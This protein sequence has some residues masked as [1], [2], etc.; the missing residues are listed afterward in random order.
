MWQYLQVFIFIYWLALFG[1]VTIVFGLKKLVSDKIAILEQKRS[2]QNSESTSN[3]IPKNDSR[4]EANH[5]ILLENKHIVLTSMRK[6]FHFFI[7]LVFLLGVF[8]DR[9]LLFLCSYGMLICLA[10][11]EVRCIYAKFF[12][13]NFSK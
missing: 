11:A 1:C 8:Y 13:F 4:S 12:F 5:M 3:N 6:F 9:N 2:T 7:C 10:L